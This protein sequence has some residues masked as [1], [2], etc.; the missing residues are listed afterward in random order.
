[1]IIVRILGLAGFH[2][3]I[4]KLYTKKELSPPAAKRYRVLGSRCRWNWRGAGLRRS[5]N[6]QLSWA[7][8]EPCW[9]QKGSP[10]W[11]HFDR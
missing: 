5:L 6:A 3:L 4:Q 11:R 8:S 1:M 7:K 9:G 10:R 2:S